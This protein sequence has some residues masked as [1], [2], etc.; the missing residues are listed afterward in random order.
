MQRKQFTFY[1]SFA[2]AARLIKT[3][4]RRCE[5]Y[6]ML[7]DYAL[8]GTAPDLEGKPPS[9]AMAFELIKPHMDTSR[10]K[11]AVGQRG[12]RAKKRASKEE[13]DD[14]QNESK[15]KEE[16]ELESELEFKLESELE[17]KLESKLESELK[18]ETETEA[19]TKTE[20]DCLMLSPAAAA[21]A[22]LWEE[23]FSHALSQTARRELEAFVDGMGAEC[24]LRAM[25]I[26]Q[27]E[28]K[29]AW[30]YVRGILSAKGGQ[31]VRSLEDWDRVERQFQAGKS[32]TPAPGEE[33]ADPGVL[34]DMER[35][36]RLVEQL[37]REEGGGGA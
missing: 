29:C 22:A 1:S 31:G 13:A 5:F 32:R 34:E 24:C 4:T 12:G 11:A 16:L 14:K 37:R 23:R 10:R 35:T 2:R 25:D 28:G 15:K 6:D 27:D 18:T 3:K 30:G 26:A 8:Y 19:E 36:R 21:V 7:I 17:S 33:R 20:G 9:V